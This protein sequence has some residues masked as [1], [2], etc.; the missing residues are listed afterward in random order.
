VPRI[1]FSHSI[2]D[3]AT[4]RSAAA[5][6]VIASRM[7]SFDV[8]DP[9]TTE[10][11]VGASLDYAAG[12][13]DFFKNTIQGCDALAFLRLVDGRVGEMWAQEIRWALDVGMPVYEVV[14]G[15][16]VPVTEVPTNVRTGDDLWNERLASRWM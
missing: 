5:L 1:Y 11:S 16:L 3:R 12:G 14:D 6:K 9:N 2:T 15:S 4:D 7:P 13:R 10:I 8:V